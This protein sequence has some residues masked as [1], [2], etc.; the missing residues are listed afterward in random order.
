MDKD[1]LLRIAEALERLAPPAR[2]DHLPDA[3]A[4]IWQNR[5]LRA[6]IAV[7]HGVVAFIRNRTILFGPLITNVVNA[8][9]FCAA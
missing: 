2:P 6:A 3:P 8:H 4:C 1:L 7:V 5:Q 9:R